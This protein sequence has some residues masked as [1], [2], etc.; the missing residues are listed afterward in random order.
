[1]FLEAL[2]G[3]ARELTDGLDFQVVERRFGDFSDAGNSAH[4]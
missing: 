4:A 3:N 1:L 2:E